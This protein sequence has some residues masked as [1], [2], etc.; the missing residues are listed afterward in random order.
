[1]HNFSNNRLTNTAMKKLLL[2]F[3]ITGMFTLA[4]CSGGYDG[5]TASELCQKCKSD[6]YSESDANKLLKQY[7]ACWKEIAK[8]KKKA[9]DGTL[10]DEENSN[11]RECLY[12]MSQMESVLRGNVAREYPEIEDK[13]LEIAKKYNAE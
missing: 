11:M 7:E 9:A 8:F 10:S 4:S 12:A 13:V 2:I 3:A 1:M 5:R 6:S